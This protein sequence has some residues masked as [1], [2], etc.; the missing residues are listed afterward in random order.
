MKLWTIK[1]ICELTGMSYLTV[2]RAVHSGELESRK[3]K[4][5][6]RILHEWLVRWLGCDPLK[7]TNINIEKTVTRT[8]SQVHTKIRIERQD[9]LPLFPA[10]TPDKA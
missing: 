2:W 10:D 5:S 9:Q 3:V 6:R 1:E 4:G 8:A 7:G